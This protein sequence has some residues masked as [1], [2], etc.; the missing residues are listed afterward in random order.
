MSEN[1]TVFFYYEPSDPYPIQAECV[2]KEKRTLACR[3]TIHS[4]VDALCLLGMAGA[5]FALPGESKGSNHFK[6]HKH[7]GE[8][9]REIF[10]ERFGITDAILWERRKEEKR[11][12][13]RIESFASM[14]AQEEALIKRQGFKV[15]IKVLTDACGKQRF[16]VRMLRKGEV[17]DETSFMLLQNA[18]EKVERFAVEAFKEAKEGA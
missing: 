18:T 16:K 14:N 15:E 1:T 10:K 8:V 4:L 6:T 17:V 9:V 11:D 2:G 7:M 12:W 3:Q 13:V 5:R